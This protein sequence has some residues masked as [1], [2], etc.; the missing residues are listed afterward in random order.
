V[1]VFACPVCNATPELV[2]EGNA[3][4]AIIRHQLGC[5]T[6]LAQSRGRW[7]EPPTALPSTLAPIPFAHRSANPRWHKTVRAREERR[8]RTAR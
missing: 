3:Q 6:L 2:A 1:D 8:Q 5:P 4:L 7:A